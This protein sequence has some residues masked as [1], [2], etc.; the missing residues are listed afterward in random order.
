MPLTL[1]WFVYGR[2]FIEIGPTLFRAEDPNGGRSRIRNS[3]KHSVP[4]SSARLSDITFKAK[5]G[6]GQ[7]HSPIGTSLDEAIT[8]VC[9]IGEG[10]KKWT[11]DMQFCL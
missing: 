9:A 3:G 6:V 10:G 11:S 4:R 5:V 1:P 7:M 8:I 2:L